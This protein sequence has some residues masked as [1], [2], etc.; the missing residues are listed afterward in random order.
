MRRSLGILLGGLLLLLESCGS[1]GAARSESD[2]AD[3]GAIETDGQAGAPID[4]AATDAA[5]DAATVPPGNGPP[6]V[7][8]G[9]PIQASDGVWTQVDFPEG[10]CRNHAQAHLAVHLNSQSKKIAIYLEGGGACFSDASCLF[11]IDGP[12]YMLGGGIFNFKNPNNPIRDWN[13]F[14]VPYCTGDVHGGSN[15]AGVPGPSTGPQNYT[16]YTNL[17]L[18]LSRILA[19][20][21]DATD[22][23]LTGVSAG[24]FGAGLNASLVM[25][26]A[27]AS[28]E[29]FTILDDSGPPLSNQ[30]IRPCLQDTWRKVWG[31]DN[32]FLKDCGTACPSQNDYIYDWSKYLLS[33]YAKGAFAPKF[34]AGLLSWDGDSTISSFFGYG[35]N[36]CT[37]QSPLTSAQFRSGLLDFR[38]MIQSETSSFGTYYVPGTSHTFLTLDGSPGSQG[39]L[40]NTEID[41]VKLTNWI[42]DLLAHKQAAHVGP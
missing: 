14:Y 31:F 10:Y 2:V 17:Q 26:N 41:G 25:G 40:Y 20:V 13:I 8:L 19:T 21:P 39:G 12:S 35:A 22:E 18:Y 11:T 33:R 37:K 4:G 29:R 30:Y 27:P 36:D 24:G 5:V 15:P 3:G 28:V 1:S 7:E 6:R 16:G 32:T 34:M 42:N 38:T 9:A 23:L